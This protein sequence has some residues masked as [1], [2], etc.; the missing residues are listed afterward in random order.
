M[1][2]LLYPIATEKALGK[3]DKEN[4]II[5]VVDMRSDK[6]AIRKE[7]EKTFGVKVSSVNTVRTIRNIKK[8]YIKL[9]KG[10]KA[11]E[12]ARKMKLV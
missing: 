12:I 4:T 7:F 10:V 9:D 11:S 6:T 3:V 8:A 2:A 5:Y 1:N